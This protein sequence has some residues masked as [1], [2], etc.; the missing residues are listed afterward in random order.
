METRKFLSR[1]KFPALKLFQVV[2]KVVN[3]L[4]TILCAETPLNKK[5][6]KWLL[7]LPS[8]TVWENTEQTGDG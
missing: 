3:R 5:Y 4:I 8:F 6:Q 2:I 1:G 7:F